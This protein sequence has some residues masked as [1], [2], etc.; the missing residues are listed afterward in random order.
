MSQKI[1]VLGITVHKSSLLEVDGVR[2]VF[3]NPELI[4]KDDKTNIKRYLGSPV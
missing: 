3:Q 2:E 1:S 4:S